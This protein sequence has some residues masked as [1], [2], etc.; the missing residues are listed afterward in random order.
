MDYELV[1]VREVIPSGGSV[2]ITIP[3]KLV[4]EVWKKAE[5]RL[6]EGRVGATLTFV[7]KFMVCFIKSDGKILME[8]PEAVL[9]SDEYP[10]ELKRNV[11]ARVV[12][13]LKRKYSDE[14]GKLFERLVRRELSE[15]GFRLKLD[16][17]KRELAD[18]ARTFRD[19]FSERE[20]HFIV[21]G[22][23]DR[24]L[25]LASMERE[26]VKEE[27]FKD[28]LEEVE[29][30]VDEVRR[31][32]ELLGLLDDRFKEGWISEKTYEML[33]ERFLGELSLAEG[34]LDK[35]RDVVGWGVG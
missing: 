21:A 20:L 1:D 10:E 29:R 15:D 8:L 13:Y 28:L 25:S 19:T 35:L 5:L 24:F 3:M 12:E 16:K 2:K 6:S 33:R 23:F 7:P 22:E 34:R 26:R 27:A 14:V 18:A 30:V 11:R 31:L 32:K 9:R 4:R 17:L